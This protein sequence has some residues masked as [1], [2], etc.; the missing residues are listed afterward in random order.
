MFII[1]FYVYFS[2]NDG[3]MYSMD[4]GIR[5]KKTILNLMYRLC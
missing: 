3:H 1:K 4:Y 5:V 2:G